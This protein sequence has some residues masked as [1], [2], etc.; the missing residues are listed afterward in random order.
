MT[1]GERP[2]CLSCR[3]TLPLTDHHLRPDQNELI[4]KLQGP[5]NIQRA[6]AYF[7]YRRESKHAALIHEMKY[8][9][10]S[11]IARLLGIEFGRILST[12]NFF[13]D[14]DAITPVPLNFWRHCRRGYNQAACFGQGLAQI[15]GIALIDTLTARRHTSQTLL[16]ANQRR[17]ALDGIYTA[18]PG[19]CNG[20]RHLLLVDDIC[21]TGTTLY[22]CAQTLRNANPGLRISVACI[23]ST[24]LL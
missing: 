9:G 5:A 2:M 20:I 1:R 6:A 4:N 14:I 7:T 11:D 13:K 16:D 22:T 18:R 8:R 24:S 15:A 10:K 12:A 3:A 23:A 17:K 21:T 19:A